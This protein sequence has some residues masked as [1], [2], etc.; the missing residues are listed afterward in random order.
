[1]QHTRTTPYGKRR[2]LHVT[3]SRWEAC[4]VF[5]ADGTGDEICADCGWLH[6][7][8]PDHRK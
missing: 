4:T 3:S 5:V 2:E 1:M 7:E 6:E 8:H